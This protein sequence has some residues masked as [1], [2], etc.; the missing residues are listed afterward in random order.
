[1]YMVGDHVGMLGVCVACSMSEKKCTFQSLRAEHCM[2][3]CSVCMCI[4]CRIRLERI[5]FGDA[6]GVGIC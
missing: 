6:F 3:F 5:Q 1:M 2:S 4:I